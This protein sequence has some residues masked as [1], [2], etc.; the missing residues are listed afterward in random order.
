[1]MMMMTTFGISKN[2]STSFGTCS[3]G[4]RKSG[5]VRLRGMVIGGRVFTFSHWG[6]SGWFLGL[7]PGGE[8]ATTF[9]PDRLLPSL[10]CLCEE[11]KLPYDDNSSLVRLYLVSRTEFRC[12][13]T[14]IFTNAPLESR[15]TLLPT[16]LPRPRTSSSVS[17]SVSAGLSAGA[18]L[19]EI[20]VIC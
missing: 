5:R 18:D 4:E 8:G 7:L 17:C 20:I 3:I 12:C 19:P 14:D 2:S 15:L 13:E 16:T 10:V 11:G 1:M 6:N 9:A